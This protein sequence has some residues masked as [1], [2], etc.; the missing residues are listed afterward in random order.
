VICKRES[1]RDWEKEMDAMKRWTAVVSLGCLL[2]IGVAYAQQGK[3]PSTGVKVYGE[4]VADSDKYVIGPEDIL[5][6]H[7]W[8]EEALTRQIPVRSDGRISLPV[9]DEVHAAGLTPLQLKEKLTLRLKEFIDNPS[10]SVIVM[11]ANSQKVFVSGEVRTPGVYRLRSETTLLQI[12][13]M[14]GGFTEWADQKKIVVIRK[15]SEKDKRMVVNYKKIV[16]GE[17]M[18]G[19][20]VLKSGDTIIVP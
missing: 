1:V 7:V 13:P 8:N 9:I 2:V 15:E 3:A 10:V 6:I 12:I 5:Y 4:V 18:S 14:A 17:D 16:S 19:N 20:I 11:E